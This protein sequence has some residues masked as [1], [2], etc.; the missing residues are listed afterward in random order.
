MNVANDQT[1]TTSDIR[2]PSQRAADIVDD[3]FDLGL[4]VFAV[5]WDLSG[6]MLDNGTLAKIAIGGAGIRAVTRRVFRATLGPRI[7]RWVERQRDHKE[8]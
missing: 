2:E 5:I 8:V 3:F 7:N 1:T 6:L 4:I